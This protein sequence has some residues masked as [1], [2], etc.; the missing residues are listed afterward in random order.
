MAYA[1]IP[2]N[3][4]T[5]NSSIVT[6]KNQAEFQKTLDKSA[7]FTILKNVLSW[8]QSKSVEFLI[9]PFISSVK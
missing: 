3:R 5:E 1:Y 8:F 2:T 7:F 4:I 9:F 6:T